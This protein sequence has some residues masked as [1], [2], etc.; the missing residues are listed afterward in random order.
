MNSPIDTSG[1][2]P[3]LPPI[4]VAIIMVTGGGIWAI[5]NRRGGDKTRL[6]VPPPPTWPEMWARMEAQD[7]KI[8]Q[9]ESRI[10]V[11]DRAFTNILADAAKQWPKDA[12][13]PTFDQADLDA[14]GDTI[15]ASWAR[16]IRPARA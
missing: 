7:S 9:L 4:I 13:G 16:R 6:K 15:P 3:W 14:L 12:P 10:E 11:R 2:I 5:V 1:L 8:E